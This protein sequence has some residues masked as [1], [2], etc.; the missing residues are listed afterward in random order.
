[1]KFKKCEAWLSAYTHL[2]RWALLFELDIE[3]RTKEYTE[4][5]L[6]V[7][8]FTFSY[9]RASGSFLDTLNKHGEAT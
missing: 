1:M 9:A 2:Y 5:N 6:T 8:C 3:C 4:I 7:L